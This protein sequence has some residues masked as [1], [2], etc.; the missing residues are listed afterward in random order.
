MEQDYYE[1]IY[2]LRTVWKV[3]LRGRRGS[4]S[5]FPL[6]C[7]FK[8]MP[9]FVVTFVYKWSLNWCKNLSRLTTYLTLI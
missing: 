1:V 4:V 5:F 6:E 8:I 2:Y 9:L 7:F 3:N